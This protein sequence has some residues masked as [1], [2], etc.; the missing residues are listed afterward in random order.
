MVTYDDLF[1]IAELFVQIGILIVAII[2][3]NKKK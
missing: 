2:S 3:V 1:R